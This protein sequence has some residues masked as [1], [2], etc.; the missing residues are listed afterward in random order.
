MAEFTYTP[1]RGF[2]KNITPAVTTAKFGD[3]YAQRVVFG[4]NNVANSWN[5]QFNSIPVATADAIDAFL[6]S[7]AGVYAFTFR[8]H[9]EDTDV[10]VICSTWSKVYESEI[11]RNVSATFERVY[12]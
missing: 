1:S 8:P 10:N 9:G 6:T 4:I 7:K 5:L 12:G 11:S 2:T 3:G